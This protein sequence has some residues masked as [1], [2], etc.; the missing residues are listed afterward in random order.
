MTLEG[1]INYVRVCISL[2]L[3][4]KDSGED[5]GLLDDQGTNI[6]GRPT[7]GAL[8]TYE[9]KPEWLREGFETFE[10][11]D[12]F[13]VNSKTKSGLRGNENPETGPVNQEE[14]TDR[15]VDPKLEDQQV[16]HEGDPDGQVNTKDENYEQA[17]YEERDKP[18]NRDEFNTVYETVEE[19]NELVQ[20]DEELLE[21]HGSDIET[22]E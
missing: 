21:K 15:Q 11:E 10:D 8:H 9:D 7:D 12:T 13:G 22:E 2:A 3:P 5:D 4:W 14:Q 19:W 16:N 17:R 1:K 18:V 6:G 20:D